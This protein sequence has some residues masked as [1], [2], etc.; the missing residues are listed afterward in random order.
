MPL[1]TS[2]SSIRKSV[3]VTLALTGVYICVMQF[4]RPEIVFSQNQYQSNIIF[5]QD[6][7]YLEPKPS[8]VIVGSS[9]STR[10]K[11]KRR[12]HIYNLAFGGGGPL[13]GLELIRRSAFVPGVIYIESNIFAMDSDEAFLER[14]FVPLLFELRRELVAFREKYQLLTVAGNL[15]YRFAGRSREEKLNRKVDKKLLDKLVKSA[16]ES[17]D[18]FEIEKNEKL[19][20]HW[21]RIIDYF[22]AKGTKLL[23][24][25]MPNDSRLSGSRGR[26]RVR[27]W[28]R[29][30]FPDIP[31]IAAY[32][33][34]DNYKTT[35]GIHLTPGSADAFTEYFRKA[36]A[37]G[38]VTK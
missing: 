33:R 31:Y 12:D 8:Q 36:I 1:S 13:T 32:N 38:S 29:S 28:I 14:L 10:L 16:L 17:A 3:L 27:R 18:R 26:E 6:F 7:L 34:L 4:T 2:S 24:F 9:M 37:A 20:E 5:A 19:L 11:F 25:E 15:I 21:H 23:F 30:A 22:S 35:D